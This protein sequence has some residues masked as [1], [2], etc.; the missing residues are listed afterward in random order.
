MV[1]TRQPTIDTA[2]RLIEEELE[3][4][5]VEREAF[6]RFV[7]RLRDRGVSGQ[8]PTAAAGG[9]QT[10][11][12]TG[13]TGPSENLRAVRQAYRDTVMDVPHYEREYGDTLVAN[14]AAEVGPTL[15][16]QLADGQRLTPPVY[17][18][19]LEASERCRDDREDFCRLL[20]AERDSL[21]RIATELNDVESRVVELGE[22]IDGAPNSGV[23]ARV[24]DELT[25]L[26]TRCTDLAARRQ[27][28]IH[29]RS[30]SKASGVD[31][32][33]LVQYL[34]ADLETV[35]P[36]LSDIATRLESIRHQR[37]LCLR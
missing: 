34:Y 14:M 23:L 30:G 31:D 6:D 27:E 33:S 11:L 29:G 13:A 21:Q 4:V 2:L 28:T 36:A 24:D 9:A 26:E 20:R 16:G 12:L 25:A 7:S 3:L 22:R 37:S 5:T 15:A 1:R 18:A 17:D 32:V 35:T 10:M 19:L 8:E